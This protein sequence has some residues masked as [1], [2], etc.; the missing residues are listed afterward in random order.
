MQLIIYF[1]PN[2]YYLC[3]YLYLYLCLYLYLYLCL[4]LK[5]ININKLFK[6]NTLY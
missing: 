5:I 4:Y 6:P 2:N 1:I 3:L